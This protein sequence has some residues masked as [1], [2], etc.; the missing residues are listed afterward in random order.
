MAVSSTSR[1]NLPAS[2]AAPWPSSPKGTRRREH[3]GTGHALILSEAPDSVDCMP[4]PPVPAF[5]SVL[6]RMYQ[7]CGVDS[8]AAH[9]EKAYGINVTKVSQLDVGVF[10]ID[11][12]DKSTPLVARLFSKARPFAAVEADLAVLRYLAQVDFPAERLFGEEPPSIHEG[13]GVLV[14]EFVKQVPKA[15]RPDF[16]ISSLG[17]MVGRLQGLAVPQGADRPAG[18]LHHFAEGTMDDELRAV[19]GWLDAIEGRVPSGSSA[20]LGALRDAVAGA[21][22]GD[23]LLAALLFSRALIDVVFRACLDP[24]TV[25]TAAKKLRLLQS[26]SEAKARRLINA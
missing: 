24:K 12:S 26:E 16:P 17:A 15:K 20:A 4:V 19:G 3:S 21:D 9:L 6:E 11:R 7:R 8:L 5:D 10:R 18:G 2:S 25:P 23:G 1:R 13:Q 22:G 14:S